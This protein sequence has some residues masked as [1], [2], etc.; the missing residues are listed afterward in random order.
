MMN[1]LGDLYS[2]QYDAR[3]MIV[4]RD[5]FELLEKVIDRCRVRR[6]YRFPHRAEELLTQGPIRDDAVL[7]VI[8]SALYSSISTGFTTRRT[9]LR[10][11]S[12]PAFSALGRR[13]AW[14]RCAT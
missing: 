6:Q 10:P 12:P 5:L 7:C 4:I 9:P 11:W 3:Q 1:L 8:R 14:P 13:C 2:G